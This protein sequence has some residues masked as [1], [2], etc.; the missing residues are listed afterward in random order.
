MDYLVCDLQSAMWKTS[1]G[2]FIGGGAKYLFVGN[3]DASDLLE[4]GA[5]AIDL[6][7]DCI[8]AEYA[9]VGGMHISVTNYPHGFNYIAEYQS[10]FLTPGN[11]SDGRISNHNNLTYQILSP[12][13]RSYPVVAIYLPEVST[14]YI[15]DHV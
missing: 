15:Y 5:K 1:N 10:G 12:L 8:G 11:D 3:S 4:G 6:A 7:I 13:K 9:T 2:R 14:G